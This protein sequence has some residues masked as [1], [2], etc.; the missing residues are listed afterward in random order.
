MD[1]HGPVLVLAAMER[2]FAALRTLLASRLERSPDAAALEL[3]TTGV[4]KVET[5]IAADQAIA[6]LS[7]RWVIHIGCAGAYEASGLR[8]GD[9][10]IGSEEVFGDEG[11]ETPDGFLTMAAIGLPLAVR[12]DDRLHDHVPVSPPP[13]SV[14]R[15]LEM[16]FAPKVLV[17]I[18]RLL[19]VSTGAGT[20]VIARRRAEQFEPLAESMEGAASGVAAWRR[21]V[22]FSEVR[23]ISNPV[24]DRQRDGWNIDRACRHAAEVLL[25]WIDRDVIDPE[26]ASTER[27]PP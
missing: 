10:A 11:V 22:R 4:G 12:G 15:E 17:R 6:E 7:P 2:E 18:G 5:A 14:A 1:E 27:D 8:I 23:G 3:R 13:T 21:S 24:G 9:V 19:T 26:K 25:K 16:L 20:D